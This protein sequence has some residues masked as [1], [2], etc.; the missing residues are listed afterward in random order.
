MKRRIAVTLGSVVLLSA[1]FAAAQPTGPG[2]IGSGG[3]ATAGAAVSK[4]LGQGGG[5]EVSGIG[6]RFGGL[7]GKIGA[8]V[9]IAVAGFFLLGALAA[10]NVGASVGVVV[11]TLVALIFLVSPQS[12]ESLAK[13]LAE[14][15]F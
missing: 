9:V 10:R 14:T 15:V 6:D 7:A 2:A 13:G 12:I 5:G 11:I 8:P 3:L 1:A 4:S